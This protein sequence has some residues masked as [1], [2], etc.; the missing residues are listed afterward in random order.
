MIG[1]TVLW[2]QKHAKSLS[3]EL[4]RLGNSV[5]EG[6]KPLYALMIVVLLSVI[7]EGAEIVLFSY[8]YYVSGVQIHQSCQ[9]SPATQ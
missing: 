8:S 4:K 2:M 1:W 5:K 7:R 9:G 3:G 6:K